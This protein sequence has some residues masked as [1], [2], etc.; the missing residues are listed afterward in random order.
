[1]V[2]GEQGNYCGDCKTWHNNM[3]ESFNWIYFPQSE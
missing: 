1:M 3:N 2:D